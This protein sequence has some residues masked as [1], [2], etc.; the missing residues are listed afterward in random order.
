MMIQEKDAMTILA[1]GLVI[2]TLAQTAQFS[3]VCCRV[4]IQHTKIREN[5]SILRFNI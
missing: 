1:S 2:Y 3:Y 5:T 4:L